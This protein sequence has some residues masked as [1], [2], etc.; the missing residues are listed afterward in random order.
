MEFDGSLPFAKESST[1]PYPEPN[2][3]TWPYSISLSS[4]FILSRV[5]E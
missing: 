2:D 1:S 3:F 4:T 5:S